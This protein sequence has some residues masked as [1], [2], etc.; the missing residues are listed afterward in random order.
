MASIRDRLIRLENRRRF[1]DWASPSMSFKLARRAESYRTLYRTDR[2]VLDK[3]D[4]KSLLRLWEENERIFGGRNREELEFYADHGFRVLI[5][6]NSVLPA[7]KYDADPFE[8]QCSHGRMVGVALTA[9]LL[10]VNSCPFR[11]DN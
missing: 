2:A 7:T 9:L 3:L 11:L 5:V 10:V 1:L 6:G 8:S 4:R